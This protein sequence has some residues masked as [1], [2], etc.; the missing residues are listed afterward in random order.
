[1]PARYY[2]HHFPAADVRVLVLD[3]CSLSDRWNREFFT[4]K[5]QAEAAAQWRWLEAE[6]AK[7]ARWKVVVGHLPLKDHG[8]HPKEPEYVQRLVPLLERHRVQL[9][10][11]GHNHHAEFLR[12]KGVAYVTCGN[13]ADLYPILEEKASEFIGAYPGFTELEFGAE[14]LRV[15]FLDAEG[16]VRHDAAVP[17]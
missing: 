2:A 3:A 11:N 16:R 5:G 7:P 15:R 8:F 9:Y 6:L 17:R 10:L 14:A 1:M 13:G 12:E 4:V